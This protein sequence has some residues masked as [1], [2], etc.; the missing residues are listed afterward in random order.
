MTDEKRPKRSPVVPFDNR[1][2]DAMEAVRRVVQTDSSK[3]NLSGHAREQMELRNIVV[4]DVLRAL[5]FGDPIGLLRFG[6]KEGEIK[7]KV[8][9][10]PRGMREIAVVTLVVTEKDWVFVKTVMWRDE[11]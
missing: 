7:L 5:E 11:Q 3:I 10:R 4:R 2:R 1:Q 9:F 6:K 8:T